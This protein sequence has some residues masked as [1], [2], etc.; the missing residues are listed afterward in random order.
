MSK[1][2]AGKL[3]LDSVDFDLR[4]TVEEAVQMMA[5][6][7]SQKG[8]EIGCE[9]DVA[10]PQIVRGDPVR[11]RQVIV[12]L[13]GNAIKFTPRGEVGVRMGVEASQLHFEVHDTGIGI[14]EAKLDAIFQA[15]SQ[16]DGSITRR[17]GG[18]G[19]GLT[20][21]QRLVQMMSGR[22]W[23]ESK[24]GEGTKFHFTVPR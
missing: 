4:E 17:F 9:T 6:A 12:N 14:P 5:T 19:L 15:F 8:L 18:T 3:E 10:V 13:V 20:I 7:A 16:A 22:T 23:L 1:I 2:E 24:P 21:S 11:L